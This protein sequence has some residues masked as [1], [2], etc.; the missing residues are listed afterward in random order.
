MTRLVTTERSIPEPS[1]SGCR[2]GSA[3]TL[4]IVSAEAS[5][6]REIVTGG[7]SSL[8]RHSPHVMAVHLPERIADQF[9]PRSVGITE[10]QRRP[11]DVV[12]LHAGVVELLLQTLP[13]L[14]WR[15]DREVVQPAEHL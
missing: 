6:R 7:Q 3:R 4:K 12:V 11:A 5:I 8:P 10:V 9:E 13:V 1:R 2:A 14:G 15:R